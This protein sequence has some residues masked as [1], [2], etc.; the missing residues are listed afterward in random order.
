[1]NKKVILITFVVL[2][3]VISLVG[4]F[5][6]SVNYRQHIYRDISQNIYVSNDWTEISIK[7]DIG[8]EKNIQEVGIVVP[9]AR[10]SV[11]RKENYLPNGTVIGPEVE[12]ADKTGTWYRLR[13]GSGTL[14][15]YDEQSNTFSRKSINFGLEVENLPKNTRFVAVRLRSDMPFSCSKIRWHDYNMK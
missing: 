15:D 10:F 1:M 8:I 13:P 3:F 5:F 7:P 4:Y 11:N 14:N 9:E 2:A 12:I 6:Y